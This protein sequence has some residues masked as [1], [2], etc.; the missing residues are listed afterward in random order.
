MEILFLLIPISII[1]LGLA[2]WAFFWA[3]KN[4]QFDDLQGPA[5]SILFDDEQPIGNKNSSGAKPS[6]TQETSTPEAK[7]SEKTTLETTTLEPHNPVDEHKAASQ[8]TALTPD[9][10]KTPSP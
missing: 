8:D 6:E 2:I 9:T 4:D 1:L 5:Y 3:V 10:T 7:T